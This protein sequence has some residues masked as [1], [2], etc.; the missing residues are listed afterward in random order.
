[1][2]LAS[3][4]D[5]NEI[6]VATQ[7]YTGADL[8][9]LCREAAVNAMQNNRIKIGS[10][11]F[12]SGLKRVKPSITKD[13]EQWYSSIKDEVSKVIPKSTDKIFYG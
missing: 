12:A 10:S 7:N 13:V 6:A 1:M 9:S 8:E 11:D 3:D 2:P 4:I 5:L